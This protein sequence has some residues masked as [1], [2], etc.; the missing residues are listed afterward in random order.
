MQSCLIFNAPLVYL[1]GCFAL[2]GFALPSTCLSSEPDKSSVSQTLGSSLGL[3]VSEHCVDCHDGADGEGGF[4]L[5]T[6][7]KD[8]FDRPA[9]EK[10]LHRWI[11]VF[12]RVNKNEM[13]PPEDASIDAS[14]REP[15]LDQLKRSIL[16]SQSRRHQQFGRVQSRRLTNDQLSATLGDLLAIDIPL[17]RLMPEEPRIDG[18]R[19]I[20]NAQSMSHYHLEDHLRVVDVALD[21]AFAKLRDAEKPEVIDLP[22]KR[23]ANK[24]PGQRNRDPE[25]REEA[26]VIWMSTM[27]FYGR[28]SRSTVDHSG[29]YRITL[30]ASSIKAPKDRNVWCSIRSGKCVSTA[31]LMHWI[32]SI[33]LTE[34]PQTYQFV[35]WIEED[36]M[37]EI[38]PADNT[39]KKAQFRGGQ[40]GV[41]EGEPQ[42]VPGIAMHHLTLERIYPGGTVEQTKR[43]LFGDLNAKWDAKKKAWDIEFQADEPEAIAEAL[44][45][46]ARRFAELA[47]RR[48][49]DEPTF[50]L[51]REIIESGLK[52]KQDF[53]SVLRQAYRAILCSPRMIYFTE[54]PGELDE[55]AIAS[56]LSYLLVGSM[57]D[58]ELRAAAD[59]GKLKSPS[60]IVE[61]ANR[62]LAGDHLDDF[63]NDFADQ[64]LDLADI[65]FTEPDRRM[66]SEFDLVVQDAMLEETRRY[67]KTLVVEN[68]PASELVDSDFTW[69]NDRLARYYD[70]DESIEPSQWQRVDL[71][72]HQYRG[73][74][75]THG[76]V[77]KV[78]ANG[79]DTSPVLRGVWIC[80]RLLGIPI[81]DP[82]ENVPAIEPDV[83]GAKTVR[84][85][86]AKH[87]EDTSCASC[88]AMIDP[89]GFALEQFD[90]AG[91]W[92]S[93][94]LIR[95][96]GKYR[97][98]PVIDAS[99]QMPD[100]EHFDSFVEFRELAA[101]ADRR[102][103]KNFVS[104]LLVYATGGPMTFSDT[105]Q[106]DEIIDRAE[107]QNY[108]LRSLIEAAVTSQIFLNK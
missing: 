43:S 14:E 63:I 47:F 70:I 11:R 108:G 41:G 40:V 51:Y 26:A 28:I 75:M 5:G 58:S 22:A 50:Q 66:F 65:A 56:R 85:M 32:D 3:F 55:Y 81:P 19:N 94:Y 102:V 49:I 35:A 99:Y 80:D 72:D 46:Q 107:G 52:A 21:A 78:T 37:L 86:L 8:V 87:R 77:L 95:R 2:T 73:G 44:I 69:L 105:Q 25:L 91:R 42:K 84:E 100:G 67:L 83:R 57:P 9:T 48:P 96:S 82:P 24:R 23:I 17:A 61:H 29:W 90:A 27:A 31:A 18:F 12:E 10:E 36:H 88:H 1:V 33:E 38:R 45:E 106:L 92:R 103:A 4:D 62:L 20:A 104:Q 13:P 30:D 74:L 7:P 53:V 89:P 54:T 93:N 39:L 68:R 59:L 64:W 6:L 60:V 79:T 71:R 15:F 101:K 16:S 76:S 98:G 97:Q 34:Q